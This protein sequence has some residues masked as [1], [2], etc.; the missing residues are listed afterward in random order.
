MIKK[1]VHFNLK[2]LIKLNLNYFFPQLISTLLCRYYIVE[3]LLKN[4]NNNIF[5]IKILFNNSSTFVF[6]LNCLPIGHKTRKRD[7]GLGPVIILVSELMFNN[8]HSKPK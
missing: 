1:I 5:I 2:I 4:Y 6:N 3:F 7:E 8:F